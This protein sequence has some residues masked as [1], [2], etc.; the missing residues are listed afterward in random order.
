VPGGGVE[1]LQAPIIENEQIGAAQVAQKTRKRQ[2]N[3]TLSRLY[4][5]ETTLPI[6]G[7]LSLSWS[8][9]FA[10]NNRR[11][12]SIHDVAQSE[13]G[14]DP[15]D[16]WQTREFGSMNS[17][18]VLDI[19][20][21]YNRHIIVASGHQEASDDGWAIQNAGLKRFQGLIALAFQCDPNEDGRTKTEAAQ[22][23]DR[24]IALNES[25]L[26]QGPLPS[27]DRGT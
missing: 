26:F 10:E 20:S 7:W 21:Q 3:R 1:R 9:R 19:A 18:E 2:L 6:K 23:E 11:N 5:F 25:V 13:T 12:G 14:L 16:T 15:C 8:A 17:L 22:I 27:R 4:L 24:L